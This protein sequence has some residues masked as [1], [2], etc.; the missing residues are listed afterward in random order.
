MLLKP[1]NWEKFQHYKDRCPPWIKLHRDLLNDRAFML[2][3]TASKAI[4]PLFW[5]LASESKHKD[6]TF[7]ASDDELEFRLRFPVKELQIGRKSLIDKGFFLDASSVLADASNLHTNAIPETEREVER[8]VEKEA[9]SSSPDK[10]PT[11]PTDEIFSLYGKH[12]P[13]LPE[14]RVVNDKRKRLVQKFWRFVLTS[15]RTDGQRRA[16]DRETGLQWVSGF[17]ERAR[18]NDFVMGRLPKIG[19]HANWV[20]DIDYLLSEKGISQVIEKTRLAA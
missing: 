19:N 1:K 14:I 6:G 2:L 8:E 16:I 3:P 11:C 18:D 9:Y 5:L 7:D 4:A 12:L 13:E 20:A 15:K 10:L 17:F